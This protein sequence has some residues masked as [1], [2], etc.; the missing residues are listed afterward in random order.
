MNYTVTI[1]WT[2]KPAEAH[3]GISR[4]QAQALADY[5]VHT[6][7]VKVCVELDKGGK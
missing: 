4:G 6:Y 3:T 1:H 5:T 7:R 2:N